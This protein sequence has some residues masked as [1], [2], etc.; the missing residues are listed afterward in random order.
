M[1]QAVL[2]PANGEDS[3]LQKMPNSQYNEPQS[4]NGRHHQPQSKR[5]ELSTSDGYKGTS[6]D[7]PNKKNTPTIMIII[8]FVFFLYL[9]DNAN[10][11]K[12]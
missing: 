9:W 12:K 8:I 1:Y 10:K 2:K 5:N 4:I 7:K 6:A 11:D 3:F